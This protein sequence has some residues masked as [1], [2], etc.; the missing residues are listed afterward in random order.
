MAIPFFGSRQYDDWKRHVFEILKLKAATKDVAGK[1][2]RTVLSSEH[3]RQ[4]QHSSNGCN[5][6]VGLVA[7][8]DLITDLG[9]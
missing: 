8:G 7:P 4:I 9:R 3:V 2:L 5:E 1:L 6:L